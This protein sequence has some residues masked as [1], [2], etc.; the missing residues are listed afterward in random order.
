MKAKAELTSHSNSA[1]QASAP[2][3]GQEDNT[4][5]ALDALVIPL[6]GLHRDQLARVGGKAA[7]LGEM[8]SAGLPVPLGF[9]VTTHA[10]A[11][12]AADAGMD[13]LLAEAQ[14]VD[15][16]ILAEAARTRLLNTALPS[17]IAEAIL[18]AYQQ[19]GENTPVAVRSSATAE[20]LPGASFAGQQDTYLNIV[21]QE[22][23]LNAVQRCFASLWSDRAV[24]Y[25][26]NLKVDQRAVRLA[27]V[28]Q[29][30]VDSTV[31][32]VLFTA[33]PLTG[34]R[35]QAVIDA[36]PGLGE[37]VVSGAS[38][39]DHFVVNSSTGEIV[40]HHLGDKKL[41]ISSIAGGGTFHAENQAASDTACLTDEQVRALAR[42]GV[43]VE[44]YYGTP[45]DI[46]WAIDANSKLWL[47]QSRPITTLYP[48]PDNT[49]T[50]D[51]DLR[52]Y[53]SFN[54]IQGVFGPITPAGRSA[55]QL[56]TGTVATFMG[57]SPR[58]P[59]DGPAIFIEA[60]ER[61]YIDL[62]R[63]IRSEFGSKLFRDAASI[64][65][66]RSVE[67]IEQ[68][69]NDP[70]LA[71]LPKQRLRFWRILA[72]F[73]LN[74]HLPINVLRTLINP[75]DAQKRIKQFRE[76]LEALVAAEHETDAIEG[77]QQFEQS[78]RHEVKCMLQT[79]VPIIP[80]GLG[81]HAIATHLLGKDASP[82]DMQI[83]LRG[84]PHNPT[85]EMDL[86]LWTMT[87]RIKAS[88]PT[89]QFARET[90][91][92]EI[93]QGYLSGSLP[94]LLQN[95]L[96][97]FLRCYGHRAVAEIDMGV[98]RWSED[99][100]HIIGVL[101]N[102]LRLEDNIASP[103]VQFERGVREAEAMVAELTRRARRRGWL[104]GKLVGFFLSRGRALAGFREMPK[105]CI[106]LLMAHLR[107]FL[108]AIGK[109]LAASGQLENAHDVIFLSVPEVHRA[110]AGEDLRPLVHERHDR[111]ESEMARRHIP[112]LLLSDGTEPS[113]VPTGD[114]A[115]HILTGAPASPGQITATA[116]VILNPNGAHLEPGEILVAPSTDP[117]WTP[118][119]LTAGGLIMEMGGMLSHGAVVAREYGI[120]AVVGVPAATER[121][122]SGQRVTI[123]GTSGT[124]TLNEE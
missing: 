39:P 59:W 83:V 102:Y 121:I 26:S 41:V 112:R 9:C 3:P 70:R 64:G 90:S 119:F 46:E 72:T 74:I 67:L 38:N 106:I 96:T 21:G 62:T 81:S 2:L 124:V 56:F 53:F 103:D 109:Q 36:N 122:T 94:A 5:Q 65:E 104:R 4:M 24:S 61:I 50:S 49:P 33:N 60:G 108:L 80:A 19:L 111:Y 14:T 79:I 58:D 99:P 98:T 113:P 118:L 30:M 15:H 6:A 34:K 63:V 20:D 7:N 27:I 11:R 57:L 101:A 43:Q 95:E 120:P 32:G 85:T 35:R 31:A 29:T 110:L 25:R 12:F 22:A 97:T 75:R 1:T 93:V 107:K 92:A 123:D 18:H 82:A 69:S 88:P 28:V 45:Q 89:A 55:L 54:I 73:F 76:H 48:L 77:L 78:F 116:R 105:Y 8:I 51:D 17:E 37:A 23:L 10:Y 68:L 40:E 84:L 117:G 47:V 100:T 13:S 114:A 66:T 91:T 115:A 87:Q 16:N 42:L 86:E 52:V 71:L 44:H